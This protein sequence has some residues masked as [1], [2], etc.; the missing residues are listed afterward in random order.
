MLFLKA[1]IIGIVL[2]H[3]T[4]RYITILYF[5]NDVEEGGETAFPVADNETFSYEVRTYKVAACRYHV[6]SGENCIYL[7]LYEVFIGLQNDDK[8]MQFNRT[9]K[10]CC[11]DA[12]GQERYWFSGFVN[13]CYAFNQNHSKQF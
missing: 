11:L 13:L 8:A 5:L 10:K 1:S 9:C 2:F 12:A 7:N 3:L 4:G 6:F